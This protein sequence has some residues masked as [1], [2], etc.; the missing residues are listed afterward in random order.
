MSSKDLQSEIARG[1]TLAIRTSARLGSACLLA[2]LLIAAQPTALAATQGAPGNTSST[3]SVDV[4]LVIGF[5]TRIS[6]LED[7]NLGTWSGAGSL[8]ANDNI[9]VGGNYFGGGYRIRASGDGEPGDPAAFT[10]SNGASRI[11]YNTFFNDVPNAG[12]DRVP[13]VGGVTLTG[14]TGT[15]FPRI[16]NFFFGCVANN[17]NI[18]IEVPES[19]LLGGTGSYSGTLTLLL[20]PE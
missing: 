17:A 16:F 13:M 9:C 15:S 2:C 1:T 19:E 20:L 6:G 18:S 8:T 12:P 4:D 10:L 11:K 5:R 3:G 14:Q 7:F